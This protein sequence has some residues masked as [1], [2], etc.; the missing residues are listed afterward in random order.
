MEGFRK[1]NKKDKK[2]L[3]HDKKLGDINRL[4]LKQVDNI[5]NDSYCLVCVWCGEF[6]LDKENICLHYNDIYHLKCMIKVH[7]SNQESRDL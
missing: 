6:I 3:E 7:Q 1:M 5:Y 4:F 2:N